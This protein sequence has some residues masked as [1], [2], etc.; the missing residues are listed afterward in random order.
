MPYNTKKNAFFLQD[1]AQCEL[2]HHI[3]LKVCYCWVVSTEEPWN[4]QGDEIWGHQLLHN[5]TNATAL[6]LIKFFTNHIDLMMEANFPYVNFNESNV[7]KI[8]IFVFEFLWVTSFIWN[9]IVWW[10]AT[11]FEYLFNQLVWLVL[12]QRMPIMRICLVR[13]TFAQNKSSVISRACLRNNTAWFSM[14]TSLWT[15]TQRQVA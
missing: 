2:L 14:K 15:Q 8:Q 12:L 1:F 6:P 5:F 10:H 11:V 7:N 13:F 3:Y 4:L 9:Y